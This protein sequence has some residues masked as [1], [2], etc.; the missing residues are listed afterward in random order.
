MSLIG[1]KPIQIPDKVKIKIE[2][3]KVFVEGPKGKL[4]WD[5]P[6]GV[7]VQADNSSIIVK[8][9]REDKIAFAMHGLTRAYV[10]NMVK[11]V[12]E[13]Y[14]KTL[15]IVG[16]GYRAQAEGKKL[17]LNLGF[18][19]QIVYAIPDGITIKAPPKPAHIIIEGIDKAKVGQAAAEIRAFFEPEPY[20]GRGIRYLGEF[21]R[22]KAGKAVGGTEK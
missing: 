6:P 18:S 19:H 3:G 10:N 1:K 22:K 4:D 8:R 16:V 20:K 15:E 21:V 2:S 9:L 7:E 14:I 17:T 5:L 12:S 11:G 13:G